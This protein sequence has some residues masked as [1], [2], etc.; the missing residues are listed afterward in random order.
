M[1]RLFSIF[2]VSI[3][4][5]GCVTFHSVTLPTGYPTKGKRIAAVESGVTLLNLGT[6]YFA[7]NEDVQS[8]L[9]RACPN[10]V[11]MGI[12]STFTKREYIIFQRY[13][14]SARAYCTDRTN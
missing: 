1:A 7:E 9:M 6:P 11:V 8:G 5:A 3:V 13:E 12:E 2:V 10:G 14:H 4:F